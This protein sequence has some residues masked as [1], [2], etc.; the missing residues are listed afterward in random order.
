MNF[1]IQGVV[2]EMFILPHSM[3]TVPLL[4]TC[5]LLAI[6]RSPMTRVDLPLPL[7]PQMA[8]FCRGGMSRLRPP[9]FGHTL[10]RRGDF[11]SLD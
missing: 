9:E 11:R 3:S 2:V 5:I 8:T 4:Y 6:L 1:Y 10:D 7:L